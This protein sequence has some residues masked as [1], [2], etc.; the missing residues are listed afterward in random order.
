MSNLTNH[1]T[2]LSKIARGHENAKREISQYTSDD[3]TAQDIANERAKRMEKLNANTAQ[4]VAQA[5]A[6]QRM[7]CQLSTLALNPQLCL[8]RMVPPPA[9]GRRSRCS[10]KQARACTR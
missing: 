5:R 9:D 2:H 3:L 7:S 8:C 10:W 4:A 6:G 1:I